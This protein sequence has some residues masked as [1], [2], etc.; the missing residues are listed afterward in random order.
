MTQRIGHY[1]ILSAVMLLLMMH[2]HICGICGLVDAPIHM[3]PYELLYFYMA[4]FFFKAGIFYHPDKSFK[5]VCFNSA[6]RLLVPFAIFTIIGYVWFGAQQANLSP[7][8]WKYWWWP[9]R[10]VF[11]VGRVEGN[12]PLWFL[13]SL[14]MVRVIFQTTKGN[15]W[16][17]IAMIILCFSVAI[18]GNHYSIRPRTISNVALGIFFY[19]LGY[20]LRDAQYDKRV[21][22]ASVCLFVAT[23]IWMSVFGWHLIDFSFNT[24]VLGIH[25]V[26]MINCVSACVAVNYLGKFIPNMPILS[27]LGRNSMTFLC[28]HVLVRDAICTYWLGPASMP[29][30]TNL[31]IYWIGIIVVCTIMSYVL[32]NKFFCWM[33]G[34][35]SPIEQGLLQRDNVQQG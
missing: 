28:I 2:H 13:L 24:T 31:A 23:Y 7:Q 11:A 35:R 12:G 16:V 26:W 25:P 22:I 6:R 20:L 32:N 1:D 29:S 27:W 8:E 3:V 30:Y 33:I 17:Q 9:L 5:E 34:A 15:K 18:L 19:G 21:G 4:Y 10:Q 14:F